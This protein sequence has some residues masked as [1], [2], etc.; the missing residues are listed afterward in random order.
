MSTLDRGGNN[1]QVAGV[2]PAT[3]LHSY[4]DE[5]LGQWTQNVRRPMNA[6]G[7]AW[8]Q[9]LADRVRAAYPIADVQPFVSE[10]NAT[11]WALES[12]AIAET[13]V[14]TAPQAPTRIP[15]AYTSRGR[16]I[17]LKQLAIAGY[18]LASALELVLSAPADAVFERVRMPNAKRA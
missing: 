11:V 1:W 18:R 4:W 8:V 3:N 5:G 13:F 2:P 14:Y 12:H 17:A 15:S 9:G 6:T 10:R 16:D 7:R